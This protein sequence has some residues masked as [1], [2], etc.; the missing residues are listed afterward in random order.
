MSLRG[1]GVVGAEQATRTGPDTTIPTNIME[2]HHKCK[3]GAKIYVTSERIY[4]LT[5]Q[6]DVSIKRTLLGSME[7]CPSLNTGWCKCLKIFR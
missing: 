2:I 7:I 1:V 4:V 5:G 6:R 3:G